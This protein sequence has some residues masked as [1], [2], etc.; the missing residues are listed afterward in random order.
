M[1]AENYGEE[2]GLTAWGILESNV[3][4]KA[5][6]VTASVPSKILRRI[7]MVLSILACTTS[8]LLSMV[9]A[10]IQVNP[11]ISSTRGC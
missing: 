6:N 4:A 8:A 2:D 10:L 5:S 11:K 3:S 7:G 1:L 9:D